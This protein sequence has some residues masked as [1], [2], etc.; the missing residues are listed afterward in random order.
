[1]HIPIIA[2]TQKTR[3]INFI[4]FNLY[5]V[6]DKQ[7]ILT[8]IARGDFKSIAR[9]LTLVENEANESAELLAALKIQP[10]PV[11]GITG[12][13]GAGKST[14]VNAL[15]SYLTKIDKKV[16]ILAVDPTSPF[17]YGALLGDRIRMAT[18]FNQPGVFI[19][20]MATRG[21]LGGLAIKTIEMVDVLKASGFDI[22]FIETVGVGQSEV[23]IAGIAD[24][25]VLVL[26]PEAGDEI[27]NIKSGIMEIAQVFV[28]N[29]SDRDG[30]QLFANNLKKLMRGQHLSIPVYKT[31][32]DKNLGIEEL[33]QE[34]L[35]KEN[36]ETTKHR[37]LMFEK[38]YKLILNNKMQ[39]I[40]KFQLQS[41]V[42]DAMKSPNFNIYRFVEE[43]TKHS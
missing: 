18:Q 7:Y 31:V 8:G 16:A 43:W 3:N 30:A 12:P 2:C 9:M 32:A 4:L 27:Q 34:L 20:S 15:T 14:L 1:M 6:K 25:T 29:K 41:D 21:A 22:I 26:V 35:K 40:D 10:T 36:F 13:P 37:I 28:V 19:R 17:N 42:D 38:A 24:K 33:A 23:E 11:I 5:S 39:L